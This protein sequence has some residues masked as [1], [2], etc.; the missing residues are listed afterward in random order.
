MKKYNLINVAQFKDNTSIYTDVELEKIPNFMNFFYGSNLTLAQFNAKY[1]M[2]YF[3]I[4]ETDSTIYEGFITKF[5]E[6]F[7]SYYKYEY[8]INEEKFKDKFNMLMLKWYDLYFYKYVSLSNNIENILDGAKDLYTSSIN[9]GV[10]N[11]AYQNDTPQNQFSNDFL[12][13]DFINQYQ[14]SLLSEESSNSSS[15]ERIENIVLRI[16]D[17]MSRVRNLFDEFVERFS[18][19]FI[20]IDENMIIEDNL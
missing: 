3:F 9:R 19:M 12:N 8:Y 7:K 5:I 11:K 1:H 4:L 10:D 6:Y 16:N 13:E 2:E 15:S 17:T 20:D 14:K 18:I